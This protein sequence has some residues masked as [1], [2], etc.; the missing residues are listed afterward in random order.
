M[1][2]EVVAQAREGGEVTVADSREAARSVVAQL[3]GQ[4]LFAKLYNNT[5]RLDALWAN[6]LPFSGPRHP[7]RR[8]AGASLV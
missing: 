8:I 6:C 3:E 4:V 5:Q 1:V 7:V 2:E